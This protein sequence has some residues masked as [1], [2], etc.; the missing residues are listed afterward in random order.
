[1]TTRRPRFFKE[2]LKHPICFAAFQFFSFPELSLSWIQFLSSPLCGHCHHTPDLVYLYAVDSDSFSAQP[3]H[4]KWTTGCTSWAWPFRPTAPQSCCPS[5]LSSHERL[6]HLPSQHLLAAILFH[7]ED[8]GRI[9]HSFLYKALVRQVPFHT[10]VSLNTVWLSSFD[11]R[12]ICSRLNHVLST[13][14]YI[15]G[16][17]D[18]P[19]YNSAGVPSWTSPSKHTLN[20]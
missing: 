4:D 14:T 1:M 13:M 18:G 6:P 11:T 7:E 2:L 3:R 10:K 12:G 8:V 16:T 5:R 17:S 15:L 9:W 20:K 19:N